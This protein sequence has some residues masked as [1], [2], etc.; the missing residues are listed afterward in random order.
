MQ[1]TLYTCLCFISYRVVERY[2]RLL[3]PG[4]RELLILMDRLLNMEEAKHQS[5]RGILNAAKKLECCQNCQ[6]INCTLL[7]PNYY[8]RVI[9]VHVKLV[10][11]LQK[12]SDLT[13][14]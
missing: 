11:P 1:F 2:S 10:I 12:F 5:A 4:Y 9:S 6:T 14:K 7:V 8:P 3:L 13:I